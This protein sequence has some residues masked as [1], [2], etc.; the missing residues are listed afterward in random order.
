MFSRGIDQVDKL[1]EVFNEEVFLRWS[2]NEEPG[3][4]LY[5]EGHALDE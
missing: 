3:L 5:A 4:D 2:L 1:V